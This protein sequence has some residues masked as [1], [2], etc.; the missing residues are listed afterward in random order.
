LKVDDP[1]ARSIGHPAPTSSPSSAPPHT[2]L[3]DSLHTSCWRS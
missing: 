1:A 2:R 3:S